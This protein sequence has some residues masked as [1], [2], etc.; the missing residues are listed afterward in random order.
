MRSVHCVRFLQWIAQCWLGLFAPARSGFVVI[1]SL[2]LRFFVATSRDLEAALSQFHNSL[3]AT[4]KLPVSAF[5]KL[6]FARLNFSNLIF[7]LIWLLKLL[8]NH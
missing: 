1:A 4:E 8:L 2:G 7:Y 3:N 5:H 6:V